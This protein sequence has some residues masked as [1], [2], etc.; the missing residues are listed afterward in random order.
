MITKKNTCTI[1][2]GEESGNIHPDSGKTIIISSGA[3]VGNDAGN[4]GVFF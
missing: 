1:I 4:Y 2:K 3:I